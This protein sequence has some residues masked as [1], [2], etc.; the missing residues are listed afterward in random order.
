M[1]SQNR[2]IA[3]PFLS[4]ERVS[5]FEILDKYTDTSL[6]L[7]AKCSAAQ[8]ACDMQ[9]LLSRFTLDT[10]GE[11]LFGTKLDTLLRPLP[12]EGFVKLGPKGSTSLKAHDDFNDFTEAF[13]GVQKAITQRG[14]IGRMWPLYELVHDK[15]EAGINTVR[16]WVDPLVQR[17]VESKIQVPTQSAAKETNFLTYMAE[18]TN[19]MSSLYGARCI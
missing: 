2:A 1:L 7:L 8:R 10:A 6:T 11:F 5:D 14:Q 3:R 16:R 12:E 13:E 4:R 15:T 17:A 9:D 18:N 19:G